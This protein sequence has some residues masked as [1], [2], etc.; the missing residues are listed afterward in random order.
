MHH[1]EKRAREIARDHQ[2]CC[3]EN[4]Y[5]GKGVLKAVENV[6]VIIGDELNGMDVENQREI[7]EK[8][9]K[10]DG[11]DNKSKLGANA[12][13]SVSMAVSKVA[14]KAAVHPLRQAQDRLSP[15]GRG[16]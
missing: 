11:T 12:I 5:L 8:M 3:D 14:A 10:T 4:R 16:N 1:L 9:I 2:E 6:N 7:D 13:L 15:R